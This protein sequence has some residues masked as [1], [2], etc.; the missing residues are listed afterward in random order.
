MFSVDLDWPA[1]QCGVGRIV[2]D[3]W[4][5]GLRE[6]IGG[7]QRDLSVEI[8]L[9][10]SAEGDT[11]AVPSSFAQR[12][13]EGAAIREEILE[14]RNGVSRDLVFPAFDLDHEPLVGSE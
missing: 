11:D 1:P 5:E 8:G 3:E 12:G 6:R 2:A 9:Q 14:R 4:G 10:V 7:A 13:F